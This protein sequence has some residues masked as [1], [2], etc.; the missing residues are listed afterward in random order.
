MF[1]GQCSNICGIDHA[2]M[3]INVRVV[4]QPDYEAWLVEAKKQFASADGVDLAA[5][6]LVNP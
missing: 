6:P 4:S 3:P 5:A 1:Y 2:F